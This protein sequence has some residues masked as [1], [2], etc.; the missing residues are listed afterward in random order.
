MSFEQAKSHVYDV[1]QR[2]NRHG[3]Q[4]LERLKE[5]ADRREDAK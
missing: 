2:F 5:K 3:V 1:E 4:L